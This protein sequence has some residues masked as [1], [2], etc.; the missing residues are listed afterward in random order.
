MKNIFTKT[1]SKYNMPNWCQNIL[2]ISVFGNNNLDSFL[3][4]NN[5]ST[6]KDYE[7]SCPRKN[8]DILT[9]WGT[10][11]RPANQDQ[12]WYDWN[13]SNWGTKWDVCDCEILDNSDTYVKLQ[14]CTAWSPPLEW[15][16]VTASKYPH[17]K[18]ILVYEESGCDFYG[19]VCYENGVIVS[20]S[21]GMLSDK[22]FDEFMNDK[23]EIVD[24][25]F[26]KY[27]E[28]DFHKIKTIALQDTLNNFHDFEGDINAWIEDI[29]AHCE[30]DYDYYQ[31]RIFQICCNGIYEKCK[32]KYKEYCHKERRKINVGINMLLSGDM[33]TS[34]VSDNIMRQVINKQMEL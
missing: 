34:G 33:I 23:D 26:E 22:V 8:E 7:L 13:C 29:I 18:F 27:F 30:N 25:I 15:L 10:C 21:D 16:S 24:E 28:N 9:F 20:E 5:P 19:E 11:P 32:N 14:F 12:N 6:C 1:S 4:D 31:D 3:H 17:L 2:E